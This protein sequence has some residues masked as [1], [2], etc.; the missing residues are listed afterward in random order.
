MGVCIQS[1]STG[2]FPSGYPQHT[3]VRDS[4]RSPDIAVFLPCAQSTFM[5]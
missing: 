1:P 2:V 4:S 5:S 3:V